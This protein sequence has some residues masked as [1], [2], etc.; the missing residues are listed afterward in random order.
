[1]LD[2]RGIDVG[3]Q[4]L[5]YDVADPEHHLSVMYRGVD[6]LG[7]LVVVLDGFQMA[8]SADRLVRP[9]TRT[10]MATSRPC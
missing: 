9:V 10:S 2:L 1:M 5:I 7:R 6:D 4:I 3:D 8:V